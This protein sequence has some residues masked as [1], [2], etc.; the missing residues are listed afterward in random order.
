[1]NL[2]TLTVAK[3]ESGAESGNLFLV[4]RVFNKDARQLIL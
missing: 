2:I 4:Y 1:M 3:A